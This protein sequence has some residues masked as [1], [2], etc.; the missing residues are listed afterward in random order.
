MCYGDKTWCAAICKPAGYCGRKLSDGDI[1]VAV[2][3]KILISYADFS[4]VCELYQP[5]V[6]GE[7]DA[8]DS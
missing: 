1:A 2:E 3:H 7:E 8:K 6:E 5:D 4:K